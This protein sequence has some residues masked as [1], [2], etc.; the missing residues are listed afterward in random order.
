M[1]DDDRLDLSVDLDKI[2]EDLLADVKKAAEEVK[3]RRASD[4]AKEAKSVEKEKS[5]KISAVMVAVGVVVVLVIAY[6]VVFAKPEAPAPTTYQTRTPAPAIKPPAVTP[7]VSNTKP[8][9]TMPMQQPSRPGS[10]TNQPSDD[11]EQPNGM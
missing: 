9:T 2:G 6:F 4:K 7:P 3:S 5:R 8:S 10:N 11:Y 1:P